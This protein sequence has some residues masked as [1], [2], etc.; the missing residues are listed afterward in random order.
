MAKTMAKTMRK[1]ER[2]MALLLTLFALLLL[3]AVGLFL[4]VSSN[5][6]TRIDA[7]YGSRLRT[8][9]SARSGLEEIRDRIKTPYSTSTPWGLADKLPQ[10][11]AG[12]PGGVLYVLNP[13]PGETVNPTDITSAYFDDDLCH[14]YNSGTPKGV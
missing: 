7:N 1:N 4:V 3:S 14:Q 13:A 11:I 6:E 9:Y 12:N 5:T 10:D 2:G 8:Y